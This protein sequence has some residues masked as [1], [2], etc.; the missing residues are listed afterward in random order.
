LFRLKGTQLI[1]LNAFRIRKIGDV[2]ITVFAKAISIIPNLLIVWKTKLMQQCF[3]TNGKTHPTT[4]RAS[5]TFAFFI[6][7]TAIT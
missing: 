3:G 1:A 5:H 7:I 6:C 2:T 4:C